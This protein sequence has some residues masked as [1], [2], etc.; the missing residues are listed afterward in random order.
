[1]A[2]RINRR[3]LDLALERLNSR[4]GLPTTAYIKDAETNRFTARIGHIYAEKALSGYLLYQ[5]VNEGGGVRHVGSTSRVALG[6][7]YRTVLAME[8]VADLAVKKHGRPF[9]WAV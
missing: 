1:M 9:D 8:E 2:Y 6:E 7:A 4:L 5:I 3:N